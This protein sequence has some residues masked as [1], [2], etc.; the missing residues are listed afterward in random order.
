[1]TTTVTRPTAAPTRYMQ[2]VAVAAESVNPTE[3]FARTRRHIGLEKSIA[4][5]GQLQEIIELRKSDILSSIT[6]RFLG[7]VVATL[8]GGTVASSA[9]WPYDFLKAVRVSANGVSNLINV[10]GAKLKV[11]DVMKHTDLSDRGVVCTVA[12]AS[13]SQGTLA[14]ASEAWGVGAST[15]AIAGGTYNVELE[16]TI[17]VGEDE[18]DLAGAIFLATASSDITLALDFASNTELFTCTGAATSVVSGTIQILS[19]KY[20]IPIGGNGQIVVPDLSLFHSMIQ[21]RTTALQNGENEIRIIGQGAG[22]SLLRVIYQLWNGTI[23][24]PVVMNRANFGKQSWRYSNNETPDEF[25]DGTHMRIDEERRYNDDIGA[26]HGFGCHDFA[27]ENAFRDVVD[28]GTTSELRLV[29]VL[30]SGLTLVNPALEYVA[31]TVFMAG[32]AA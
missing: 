21:S 17:P 14:R 8:G 25:V 1:M 4:Y 23:S 27:V 2:G 32:Q 5:A 10:S 12:G 6:V 18:V 16:W 30:Q 24:A 13:V 9:R 3:F 31:E 11:R 26:V 15:T 28:M 20:S 7:T 29:T 19:T 22:K